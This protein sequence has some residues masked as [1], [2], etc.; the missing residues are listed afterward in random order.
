MKTKDHHKVPGHYKPTYNMV[1]KRVKTGVNYHNHE[2]KEDILE[3]TGIRDKA[4]DITCCNRVLRV[5]EKQAEM[6]SPLNETMNGFNLHSA[7]RN[8]FEN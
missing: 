7:E 6:Q 5:I 8:R 4:R 1:E 3:K 2:I